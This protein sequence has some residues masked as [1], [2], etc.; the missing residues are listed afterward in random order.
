VIGRSP[1]RLRP[2]FR[3]AA[4][5]QLL[6][7]ARHDRRRPD[8]RILGVLTIA[9]NVTARRLADEW[10][11]STLES[12]SLI[13]AGIDAQG[14]VTFAN[15]FLLELTGWTQEEVIGLDWF[16]RFDG[17]PEVKSDYFECMARGEIRQHFESSIRTKTGEL[18]TI[19]WSS[20]LE[21]A[22]DGR[23]AGIV[24]IGEDVTEQRRSEEL[25]RE[26]EEHFRTLIE[27]ASDVI[28][29]LSVDGTSLYESPSLE[30][31]LGWRPD[32]LVGA[33]N[34]KLRH[35]DDEE[36]VAKAVA[37]VFAGEEVPS[38]EFRLRHKDGTWR[39]VEAIVRLRLQKG[40]R[41][42]VSNYRDVTERLE[43]Q[44]QLLHSQKLEAVGRLAGG[45]A[46][47][48]NNLLTAIGGYT[49]FLIGGFEGDDPRR[50]DALEIQ[51][52]S[53]RAAALT[54]QLLAFS[55]RQVLQPEVLD[56]GVVV[57]D[58]ESLLARLLGEDV[59]LTSRVDAGCYVEADRGQLEQ[60]ITNLA[61][62][63]R[64]AMPEGGRLAISARRVDHEGEPHVELE[65]ADTGTG[66]DPDTLTHLF[67]P[68][69]T[70]KEKGKGT[71]LGL[72]TVY[73]I[74]AQS[75][76]DVLVESELEHGSSFRVL[77]PLA[78]APVAQDAALAQPQLTLQGAET[79]LLVEDEDTIRR[80]VRDVLG[81]SGYT[82]LDAPAGDPAL[83]LLR[84]NEVD[85]LLTDVVMPGMSGPDLARIATGERP[86]IR[87]LFTSG[88]TNEPDELLADPD[89]AFIGKP[90]SPQSLVAKVR[91]VL[92]AR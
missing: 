9:E 88:Y 36:K 68:F 29:V 38:L 32:E 59:E 14:C 2:H 86:S 42:I 61:V 87:V 34:F 27:N 37:A 75:G 24:T 51:R 66:M 20:T 18:R 19:R 1:R 44:E 67:E 55:R 89:A 16:D 54:R 80:L 53:E 52:A 26:R 92:D 90:F 40:E 64:D 69:Y 73:G 58:L 57:A 17:N 21:H 22:P 12:V 72:A 46:H 91:E 13:A 48:F 41:V 33:K 28:S 63:S 45:I 70:T 77:L 49:E 5:D 8:A 25:L 35:P 60:V 39:T 50:E 71:G 79:I 65:V 85:L 7:G 81:R 4:A 62:N 78:A 3:R 43:L 74:V 56:L 15:D 6:D 23:A 31:V 11:R 10:F 47:D 76:G 82:V 84:A 30:R 83:E